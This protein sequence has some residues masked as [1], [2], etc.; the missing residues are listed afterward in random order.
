MTEKDDLGKKL[1][2]VEL[3][4]GDWDLELF[5]PTMVFYCKRCDR[6]FNYPGAIII[7]EDSFPFCPVCGCREYVWMRMED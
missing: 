1:L 2:L 5:K 7:S 6:H 4:K 3:R